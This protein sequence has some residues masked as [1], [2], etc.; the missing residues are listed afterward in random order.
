MGRY[1]ALRAKKVCGE[2]LKNDAD[3][4]TECE[5]WAQ[6]VA[7]SVLS[8]LGLKLCS[9]LQKRATQ[10]LQLARQAEM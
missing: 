6:L 10:L 1:A 9:S 3:Q 7:T 4:F 8:Y 2:K 5:V